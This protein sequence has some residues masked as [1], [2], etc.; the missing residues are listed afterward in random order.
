MQERAESVPPIVDVKQA[1]ASVA[2]EKKP[3]RRRAY[4]PEYPAKHRGFS[5]KYA[6]KKYHEDH[7]YRARYLEQR[8][9]RYREDHEYRA[10]L[11]D[12][13]NKRYHEDAEYHK[14]KLLS[15]AKYKEEKRLEKSLDRLLLEFQE[16][17]RE[18]T[19]TQVPEQDENLIEL[20]QL[21]DQPQEG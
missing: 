8:R 13:Q 2:T 17:L 7:E 20:V 1:I 5:N 4:N 3:D 10:R 6:K 16:D 21:L 19:S 14:K 15:V 9:K 12:Q 11:L 18:G